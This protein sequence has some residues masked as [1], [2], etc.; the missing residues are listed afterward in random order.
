MPS[1]TAPITAGAAL[2]A[3]AGAGP[4]F[5]WEPWSGGVGWRPSTELHDP[6]VVAERVDAARATLIAMFGL[7]EE[8]VPVRVVASV[9]FLGWAARLLSPLLGAAVTGGALPVARAADLWWRPVPA[10]P[11]PLAFGDLATVPCAGRPVD[12]VARDF[13]A[14]AVDGLVRPVL[15]VF[16]SRFVLSPKVLWGNVASALAGAAGMLADT[17]PGQVGAG[18]GRQDEGRQDEGRQDH[19][20]PGR[21]GPD[22]GGRDQGGRDPGGLDQGGRAGEIVAACLALGPLAGT[23]SLVRPDPDGP[24]RFLVRANC[25]LYYRIPGGGTCGDC[26]LTPEPERRTHRESVLNR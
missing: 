9:T 13:T 3:A 20:G 11:L 12:D 19:G 16:R 18:Q 22:Q 21:G 10:G 4:Y 25:C 23:G 7:A 8:V 5:V 6:E 24:R 17:A 2:R 1:S 26:V 15:E 14:T